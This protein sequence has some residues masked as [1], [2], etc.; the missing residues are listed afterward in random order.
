MEAA[1]G[2]AVVEDAVGEAYHAWEEA[3]TSEAVRRMDAIRWRRQEWVSVLEGNG[4]EAG[5]AV[6]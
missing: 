3:V 6:C 2:E 5:I 4:R 1:G